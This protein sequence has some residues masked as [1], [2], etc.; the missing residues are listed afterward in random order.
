MELILA[1]ET[2]TLNAIEAYRKHRELL[3]EI[4]QD[5]FSDIDDEETKAFCKEMRKELF[6]AY[7]ELFKYKSIPAKYQHGLPQQQN[8]KTPQTPEAE[9]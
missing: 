7:K 8:E 6:L 9:Q 3:E 5:G 1:G 2:N 4:Q